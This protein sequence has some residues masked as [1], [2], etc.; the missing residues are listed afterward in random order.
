[1]GEKGGECGSMEHLENKRPKPDHRQ[2]VITI[3]QAVGRDMHKSRS[4]KAEVI[5]HCDFII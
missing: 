2:R 1:V 5:K 3:P 4:M